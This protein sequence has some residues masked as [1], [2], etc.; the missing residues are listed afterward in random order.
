[1]SFPRG[2]IGALHFVVAITALLSAAGVF[3]V[4]MKTG[5]PPAPVMV[6]LSYNFSVHNP[7]N[8]A[9]RNASI[10]VGCPASETAFQQRLHI[11]SDHS[12]QVIPRDPQGFAT[13]D[14]L[15]FEWEIF[16]PF[17]TK[18][19]TIRSA[20]NL[21]ETPRKPAQ[22]DLSTYLQP[23]P[24]IES[25][26]PRIIA[27]AAVLAAPKPLQTI[28]NIFDWV[29]K[30]I[31]DIGYV[32]Q[33]RGALY[34]IDHQQ[35]DCTEFACLFVALCRASAIPA[36]VVGGFVCPRNTVLDLGDYHNWAEFFHKGRW[37]VADPQRRRLMREQQTYVAFDHWHAA[38]KAHDKPLVAVI[39]GDPLVIRASRQ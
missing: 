30:Q 29:S 18:I 34:A 20:L 17:A 2:K 36:R 10:Q 7:S 15:L 4:V 6:H 39:A 31:D 9:I 38:G 19:V 5:P 1:M 26:H 25:D 21:W 23:E 16:P 28:E 3:V 24:F 32:R 27:Q 14:A 33:A 8:Q 13:E 11:R 22:R 12:Y 35:G 37:H